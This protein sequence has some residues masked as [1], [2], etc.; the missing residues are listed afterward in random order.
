MKDESLS[1]KRVSF[2]EI[3]DKAYLLLKVEDVKEFIKLYCEKLR[4][5]EIVSVEVAIYELRQ[6]AG[7][8]LI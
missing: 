4:R 5:M 2:Q 6:L 7:A 8:E 3:Q 1:D